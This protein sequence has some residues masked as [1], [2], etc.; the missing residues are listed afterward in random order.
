M[1]LLNR[2]PA[3]FAIG[4]ISFGALMGCSSNDPNAIDYQSAPSGKNLIVPP[5]LA[6]LSND[7]LF[8]RAKNESLISASDF[9]KS[10]SGEAGQAIQTAPNQVGDVRMVRDGNTRWLMVKRSP[11]ALWPALRDFWLN[12]GFV[13]TEDAPRIGVMETDW[14]E[15]RAKIPQDFI[16][17][18]LGKVFDS[19]YS[20]GERDKFRTRVERVG[21]G[22]TEI[23]ISHKGM[24]EEDTRDKKSTVWIPAPNNPDLE[25]EFLRRLML[26][27][28]LSEEQSK[29][30]VAGAEVAKN[31]G[32]ANTAAT[33]V[34]QGQV[35][36]E[37]AIS[38]AE[39][40]GRTWRALGIALDRSGFTI[41]DRNRSTNTYYV[42]YVDPN[43]AT[44]EST[45][46][47]SSL[48]SS[49]D[50]KNVQQFQ[51]HVEKAS[52]NESIIRVRDAKGQAITQD[53]A[54]HMLQIIATALN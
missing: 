50:E 39:N 33:K 43:N 6:Q 4:F 52:N 44:T 36:G 42:R 34:K 16:R 49:E 15:N 10:R 17:N 29:S 19:I 25:T 27:L 8:Q 7:T 30:V 1:R 12:Q 41:E 14:A 53:L 26:S 24:V 48:F 31:T 40:Q 35:A 9:E 11:E 21:D 2:L 20:S 18:A 22:Y 3:F 32:G 5:D 54:K 23:F 38:F 45:G 13:L 51:I 37:P 46:F 47:F 28:G